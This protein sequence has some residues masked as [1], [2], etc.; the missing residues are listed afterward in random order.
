MRR[1][2]AATL[3]EARMLVDRLVEEADLLELSG[4]LARRAGDLAEEHG[5]RV[6]DAVH[7]ASVEEIADAD[8]VL[9]AADGDLAEAARA[10]GIN[11]A[12][13]QRPGRR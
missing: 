8:A 12:R 4:A 2:D 6:Y 13:L 5:L 3:G 7:L 9:V 1:I 10:R 11:T